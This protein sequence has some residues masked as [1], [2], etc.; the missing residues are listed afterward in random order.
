MKHIQE[1]L[2]RTGRTTRMI[3]AAI[4]AAT[5]GK[6]VTIMAADQRQ[7]EAFLRDNREQFQ[8]LG[9]KVETTQS[10]QNIDW[11]AMRLIGA[12]PDGMLCADHHAIEQRFSK[13]LEELHRYDP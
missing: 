6:K 7:R 12:D 11:A 2:R 10:V 1:G 4:A 9:I 8:Q 3:A 5:D 13:L